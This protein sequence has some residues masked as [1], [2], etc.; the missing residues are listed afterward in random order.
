MG[1]NTK[2]L[3]GGSVNAKSISAI[4]QE[5]KVQ[6]VL[7]GTASLNAREFANLVKKSTL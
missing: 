3:Y 4:M 2:I 6:G 5:G 7:V 1:K